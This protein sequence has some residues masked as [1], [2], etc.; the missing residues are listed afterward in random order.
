MMIKA[1]FNKYNYKLSAMYKNNYYLMGEYY[2][3]LT[4]YYAR[5]MIHN[6]KSRIK[7]SSGLMWN[8]NNLKLVGTL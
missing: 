1:V 4:K 8:K 3:D 6:N 7:F 5:I 2:K